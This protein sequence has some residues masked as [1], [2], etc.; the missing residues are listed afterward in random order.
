MKSRKYYI[1]AGKEGQTDPYELLFGHHDKA[2]IDEE[3]L[4]YSGGRS[5]YNTTRVVTLFEDTQVAI[6]TAMD[7]LNA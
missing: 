2:I 1:L 7:K 4:S 3:K 5:D 6:N